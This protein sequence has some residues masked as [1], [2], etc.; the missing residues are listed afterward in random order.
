MQER[1]IV[2]YRNNPLLRPLRGRKGER[3]RKKQIE[4][5]K[6]LKIKTEIQR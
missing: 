5:I 6:K 2:G 1:Y 4:Q 3:G